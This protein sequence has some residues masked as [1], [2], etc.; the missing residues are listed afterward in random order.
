MIRI[1]KWKK[2]NLK[3]KLDAFKI[4]GLPVLIFG[5][6]LFDSSICPEYM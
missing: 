6:F 4:Y 5:G 3:V 1:L 2:A